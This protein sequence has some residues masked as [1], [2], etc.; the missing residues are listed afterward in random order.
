MRSGLSDADPGAGS[1]SAKAIFV[2]LPSREK[3][4]GWRNRGPLQSIDYLSTGQGAFSDSPSES[5]WRQVAAHC[6]SKVAARQRPP[7]GLLGVQLIAAAAPLASAGGGRR[8]R[9][10]RRRLPRFAAS[11]VC[12]CAGDAGEPR[13]TAFRAGPGQVL[14]VMAR[15]VRE[16]GGEFRRMR[17]RRDPCDKPGGTPSSSHRQASGRC[18]PR[19]S[20]AL[21]DSAGVSNAGRA[22][23]SCGNIGSP[24]P[25][26]PY[27]GPPPEAAHLI[28]STRKSSWGTPKCRVMIPVLFDSLPPLTSALLGS[29][30]LPSVYWGT[31]DFS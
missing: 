18:M 26:S 16:V 8:L 15:E 5:G 11:G 24:R 31:T 29:P 27:G 7:G 19:L 3:R 1:V 30:C 4:Y 21:M 9:R 14:R 17:L 2:T 23:R 10:A 22:N 12:F 25:S 6:A 28:S 20:C 13:P